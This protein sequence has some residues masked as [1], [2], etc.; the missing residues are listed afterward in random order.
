MTSTSTMNYYAEG[1]SPALLPETVQIFSRPSI[2]GA[3]RTTNEGKIDTMS[4]T[5]DLIAEHSNHVGRATPSFREEVTTS[6][7]SESGLR[8]EGGTIIC[9]FMKIA[10]SN[11]MDPD[12]NL[13]EETGKTTLFDRGCDGK[14]VSQSRLRKPN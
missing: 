12:Y 10:F 11:A 14:M 1:R 8:G 2:Y 7:L 3:D 9:P 6:M 4:G 13:S 5:L